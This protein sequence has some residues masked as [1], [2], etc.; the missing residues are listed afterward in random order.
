[1]DTKT[2][3][4][5]NLVDEIGLCGVLSLLEVIALD[6]Q[7]HLQ[8]NWQSYEQAKQYTKSASYL[9]NTRAKIAK[10]AGVN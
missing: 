8:E 2:E 5:E 3:R 9:E 10:L 6:K 1:M 7:T 4:L